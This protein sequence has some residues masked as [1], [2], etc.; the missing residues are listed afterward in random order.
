MS[1][2][3]EIAAQKT[4]KEF[5]SVDELVAFLDE[6]G[7]SRNNYGYRTFGGI[8]SSI[9]PLAF[10][11]SFSADLA[12]TIE[13]ERDFST[14]N[15]QEKDVDE[16]DIVKTDGTHIFT[17]SDKRLLIT[18]AYP[19]SEAKVLSTI[20]F[21]DQPQ[22]M[23]VHDDRLIIFGESWN[24]FEGSA[25]SRI[26]PRPTSA[27]TYVTIFD[28]SNPSSPKEVREITLEG[29]LNESRMVDQYIY[30]VTTKYPET[31]PGPVPLPIILENNTLLR[32]DPDL[33]YVEQPDANYTF[34]T[35]TAID[36]Y[37]TGETGVEQDLYLM[38]SAHTIYASTDNL[39]LT[40]TTN[41]RENSI[42]Y[43]AARSVLLGR[44]NSE[45]QTRV[46]T[47]ETVPS[48]VLSTEEKEYKIMT[49]FERHLARQDE[50]T[51]QSLKE[52]LEN[53][54][55]KLV[56]SYKDQLQESVIHRI[57]LDGTSITHEASGS[58][59]GSINN[60]FSMS[61][62]G[63]YFRVATTKSP[64]WFARDI[65]DEESTN[66]LF[67]LNTATLKQVGAVNNLAEGERIYSARFMQDRAYLV[68]FRQVD[69][70][71]VI[72]L[73]NPRN[74]T[75]LGELKIPGFST[76]L[77][78]YG[79]NQVIGIGRDATET[80]FRQG[81]KVSLFD[82]SDV[83]NP[84]E[85]D[86]LVFDRNTSS[87]AEY[88]HKAVLF[89]AEKNLLSIPLNDNDWKNES[90]F[91]GAVVIEV[92]PQGLTERARIDHAD[93]NS[94]QKEWG[95]YYDSSVKRSLYIEDTLYT[96]SERAIKAHTIESLQP[97]GTLLLKN[98]SGRYS[99]E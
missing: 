93:G 88:E 66:H 94:P 47:I 92:T 82:V 1:L 4:L 51:Q 3:Q 29:S 48:Y 21:E 50:T 80:G 81:L 95:N 34:T 31:I 74:P 59:P 26:L 45:E 12:P 73:K 44:L 23:F 54:F 55:E 76:Y 20:R 96:I 65:L 90:Y 9:S 24:R 25:V 33:F 97:T 32:E 89:S 16:A 71:F 10:E 87:L 42:Q 14:T 8:E 35:V 61:E 40:Y 18:Q 63:A 49:V 58:V 67:V 64:A 13:K 78:P 43:E 41:M 57:A 15:T 85:T 68:T 36:L 2:S 72:D 62:Q 77:H 69:P 56:R 11:E 98:T 52:Q 91:N 28:I 5:A 75:V 17:L 6:Q 83:R 70:L 30:T 86:S 39:Y 60:Q 7:S 53:T 46:T 38:D 22:N 84:K 79:D 99:I 37:G 27:Y 19:A